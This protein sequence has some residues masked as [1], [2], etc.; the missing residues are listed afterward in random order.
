MPQITEELHFELCNHC[1]FSSFTSTIP[2]RSLC[3]Y[4]NNPK[5]IGDNNHT[6][7][8][9]R[10]RQMP[11]AIFVASSPLH[12][13]VGPTGGTRACCPQ[14]SVRRSLGRPLAV[15]T[16]SL[17]RTA[18]RSTGNLGL[19]AL[20]TPIRSAQVLGCNS[21][22]FLKTGHPLFGKFMIKRCNEW[23]LTMNG[24]CSTE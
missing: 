19:G 9:H 12:P 24:I 20:T 21:Y 23:P 6:R 17:R 13:L 7:A 8:W 11:E 4:P 3:I 22:I 5:S 1:L 2:N 18:T 15:R 16:L 10:S 14:P